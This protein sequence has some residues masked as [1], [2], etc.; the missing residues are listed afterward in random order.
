MLCMSGRGVRLQRSCLL[1]SFPGEIAIAA[2]WDHCDPTRHTI[3]I[4]LP[5]LAVASRSIRFGSGIARISIRSSSRDGRVRSG[6]RF[7]S[8]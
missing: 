3:T 1:L 7:G 5:Q 2:G 8:E 4:E 6:I